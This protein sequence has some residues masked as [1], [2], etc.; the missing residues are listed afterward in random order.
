MSGLNAVNDAFSELFNGLPVVRDPRLMLR[1]VTFDYNLK[2]YDGGTAS[3]TF[4][5]NIS[6][7]VNVRGASVLCSTI[8]NTWNTIVDISGGPGVLSNV[9]TH[10]SNAGNSTYTIEITLDGVV[11]TFDTFSQTGLG[12]NYRGFM[13]PIHSDTVTLGGTK[14]L[15][16]QN[17]WDLRNSDENMMVWSIPYAGNYFIYPTNILLGSP[18]TQGGGA[19]VG[20]MNSLKVRVKSSGTTAAGQYAYAL[21]KLL[22]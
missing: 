3:N 15:I 22:D 8:A 14:G 7:K 9:V 20:F 5:L 13:G 16:Y 6:A 17:D 4:A 18:D 10:D 21:Y 2:I 1:G 11:Y 19:L 12:G